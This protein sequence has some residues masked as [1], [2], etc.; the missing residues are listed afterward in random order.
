MLLLV[1]CGRIGFV[2]EATCAG[3][4]EDG[5]GVG[6]AC[7]VCPHRPDAD[8]LDT[9]GDAVGDACDPNPSEPRE[10]I[11]LF[12][13]FTEIR[14]EWSITTTPAVIDDGLYFNAIAGSEALGLS[15]A[16]ALDTFALSGRIITGGAAARQLTLNAGSTAHY[17]CELYDATFAYLAMTYTFDSV[18]YMSSPKSNLQSRLD[19]VDFSLSYAQTAST[20]DCGT[21]MP[22]VQQS[23]VTPLPAITATRW[24]IF[25]QHV[26]VRLDW[27]VHIHTD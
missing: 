7:D 25:V 20:L 17:Y 11:V 10:R 16:P 2:P 12:D 22:A 21:D 5:D 6:D 18:T 3:H 8:Q 4:D 9:D 27:F 26:E 1:G 23:I 19:Q 15:L 24:N 13:P 14:P